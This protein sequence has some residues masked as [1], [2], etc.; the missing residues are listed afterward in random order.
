MPLLQAVIPDPRDCLP[1]CTATCSQNCI[2]INTSLD[3][4]LVQEREGKPRE[5]WR[6][7]PPTSHHMRHRTWHKQVHCIATLSR[8]PIS[9]ATLG[10]SMVFR[11]RTSFESGII[12]EPERELQITISVEGSDCSWQERLTKCL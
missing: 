12:F 8:Y 5:A 2:S 6:A 7:A 9:L 4:I 3:I 10:R 11:G 1:I